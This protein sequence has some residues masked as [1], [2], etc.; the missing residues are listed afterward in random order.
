MPGRSSREAA[1]AGAG[2]L[3]QYTHPDDW[4]DG[5]KTGQRGLRGNMVLEVAEIQFGDT[6][7]NDVATATNNSLALNAW[8]RSVGF[9]GKLQIT[10]HPEG[11]QFVVVDKGYFWDGVL[12]K[13]QAL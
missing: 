4:K 3:R 13:L 1:E 12:E 7:D 9:E 6:S 8:A 10:Q 11:P 2:I 5:A